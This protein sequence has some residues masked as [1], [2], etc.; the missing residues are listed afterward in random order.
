MGIL[1]GCLGNGLF[2]GVRFGL[3]FFWVVLVGWVW[4]G[5][6]LWRCGLV[7]SSC[8]GRCCGGT[9][10]VVKLGENCKARGFRSFSLI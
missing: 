3:V 9:R 1:G 4:F 8:I 2:G 7:S 10:K 5:G 6:G